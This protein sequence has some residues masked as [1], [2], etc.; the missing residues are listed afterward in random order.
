MKIIKKL[1]QEAQWL[2]QEYG[3]ITPFIMAIFR[4]F[5]YFPIQ[6]LM[7]NRTDQY[8]RNLRDKSTEDQKIIANKR[9]TFM[10]IIMLLYLI[11]EIVFPL[12]IDKSIINSSWLITLIMVLLVLR[13]IDIIQVNVNM[14]LFDGLR[15]A[16]NR[17]VKYSRWIVLLIWHYLELILIFGFFY[18]LCKSDLNGYRS[19][20]DSYYFSAVTQLTIGY[21]DIYPV[22]WVKVMVGVQGIIGT[23][24]SIL[25]IAKVITLLPNMRDLEE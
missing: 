6:V 24:F 10:E 8:Y 2:K 19:I 20:I 22:G 16:Q 9:T 18:F 17:I 15:F 1:K 4:I 5:Q 7:G 14:I 3:I 25:I 12:L 11:I 21:G 23:F 13:L